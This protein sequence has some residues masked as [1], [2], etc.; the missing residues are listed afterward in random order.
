M[1]QPSIILD[2]VPPAARPVGD[3]SAWTIPL[4]CM[5]L[6]AIACCVLLPAADENRRLAAEK[7]HLQADLDQIQQQIAVNDRFLKCVENDPALLQRLAQ[8]QMKMVRSGEAV[9]K[10][11]G[12]DDRFQMSPYLLT[13]L[14]PPTTPFVYQPGRGTL[15]RLVNEPRLCLFVMGGGMLLIAIGLVLG[16]SSPAELR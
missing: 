10:L 16:V 7:A 12:Q 15:D 14:P 9:L 4:L 13:N 11:S 1:S 2:S 8:R 6:A 3:T 5:G